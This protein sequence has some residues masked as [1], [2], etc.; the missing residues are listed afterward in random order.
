MIKKNKIYII[1]VILLI[2][3]ILAA[4]IYLSCM[5]IT[6]IYTVSQKNLEL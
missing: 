1:F 6:P 5:I 2:M 3:I 4:R